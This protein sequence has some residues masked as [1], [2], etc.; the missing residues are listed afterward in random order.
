MTLNCG[1]ECC[2]ALILYFV[3]EVF[4]IPYKLNENYFWPWQESD[5][6]AAHEQGPC[7]S[8]GE[9]SD[10]LWSDE[11][12]EEQCPCQFLG[13]SRPAVCP[14]RHIHLR[15]HTAEQPAGQQQLASP[16]VGEA[17]VPGHPSPNSYPG[18]T[19]FY[20]YCEL[21][22]QLAWVRGW[23]MYLRDLKVSRASSSFVK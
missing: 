12:T 4:A 11:A 20:I 2:L 23:F 18:S 16:S 3:S 7:R 5:I 9:P 14:S 8:L 15:G 6:W 21:D 19:A 13:L 22:L 1:I 10:N 17:M